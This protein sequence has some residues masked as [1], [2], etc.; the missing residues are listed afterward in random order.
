MD[1]HQ[2]EKFKHIVIV[3]WKLFQITN[4]PEQKILPLVQILWIIFILNQSASVFLP[5]LYIFDCNNSSPK[6]MK[7][8]K[9]GKLGH[10]SY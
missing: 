1:T 5:P 2:T 10:Q 7:Y 6:S 3:L 8:T 4:V 9:S